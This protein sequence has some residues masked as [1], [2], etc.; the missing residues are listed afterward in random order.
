MVGRDE[1]LNAFDILLKHLVDSLRDEMAYRKARDARIRRLI[2]LETGRNWRKTT[3]AV[4]L[5]G[6]AGMGMRALCNAV[7]SGKL[8]TVVQNRFCDMK[9]TLSH[10]LGRE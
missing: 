9:I 3:F 10:E 6:E 7:R 8:R 4:L 2:Y 1:I 5:E